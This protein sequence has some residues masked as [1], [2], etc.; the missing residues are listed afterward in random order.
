MNALRSVRSGEIKLG[1]KAIRDRAR[2]RWI[3]ILQDLA[4]QLGRYSATW[5]ASGQ[6]RKAL[7]R[8]G[9]HVSCPVH[10]GKDGFR[11]FR[12][13]AESGGGICNTCG[14]KADGFELLRW[15]NGWTFREA[16]EAV[17]ANLRLETRKINS[18]PSV[19]NARIANTQKWA[20]GSLR[21]TLRKTWRDCMTISHP[22]A[23]VARR[24]LRNRG[25][26]AKQLIRVN[27]VR[28]HPELGYWD[29]D[30]KFIASFPAIVCLV[31]D[32]DGRPVTLQRI[33]LAPDGEKAP[34]A[35]PKKMM[36]V[37]EGRA[38]VGGCVRLGPTGHVLGV[39][40]GIETALAVNRATGMTVWAALS[41]SLL[42]RWEPPVSVDT[43]YVWADLDRPDRMTGIRRG[44]TAATVLEHKLIEK[45]R[46]A[47]V[48]VPPMPISDGKKGMDWNDVLLI[49]GRYGFP[50]PQ[51][52]RLAA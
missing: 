23:E 51:R 49:Q 42:E 7:E 10:G 35:S 30:G 5:V 32:V 16:L 20:D 52:L 37:P 21:N 2:G 14:P 44:E 47:R 8:I 12:D 24:Y 13:V 3:E 38:V 48:F 22:G 19:A 36:P 27:T 18:V 15:L 31:S 46:R 41:A 34:V 40:E 45:G 39:A 6:D 33:Y 9:R 1:V 4:P 43:V 11:L 26:S 50:S 25:L 17:A 29:E 28:F